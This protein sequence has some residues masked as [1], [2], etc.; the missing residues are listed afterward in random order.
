MTICIKNLINQHLL[1]KPNT[2]SQLINQHLLKKQS[3]ANKLIN[4]SSLI[5][6]KLNE[7]GTPKGL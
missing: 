3:Y 5:N 7:Y 2:T 6:K 4:K 1:K